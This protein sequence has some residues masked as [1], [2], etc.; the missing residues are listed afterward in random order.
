M[1][2]YMVDPACECWPT[3]PEMWTTHYGAVEPGSAIEFNPDC[4]AHGGPNFG[5]ITTDK[6]VTS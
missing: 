3:P 2:D 6:E 5:P 4:P 1:H